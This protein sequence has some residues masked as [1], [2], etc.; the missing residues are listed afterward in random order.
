M[1][2]K[3]FKLMGLIA[4]VEEG[5]SLD[6]KA[7]AE[8]LGE[9][10]ATI[11]R[12]VTEIRKK[13]KEG[14]VL[15][16]MDLDEILLS[17]LSEELK[18]EVE[19]MELNLVDINPVTGAIEVKQSNITPQTKEAEEKIE[20]FK[21]G[22]EGLKALSTELQGVA[23]KTLISISTALDKDN[24]D[25]RD[26]QSLAAALTSIQNAFFNKP[27]TNVNVLKVDGSDGASLLSMFK[28]EMR[29]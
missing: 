21:K 2:D 14:A 4:A 20:N 9:K 1:T 24:V 12:W 3:K 18:E 15:D 13:Q 28:Q 25:P 10:P 7:L 27:T 16:L 26:L 19:E 5:G 6:S 11:K 8:E 29:P 23:G 17:K 22:V